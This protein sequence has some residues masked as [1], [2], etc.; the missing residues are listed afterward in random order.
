MSDVQ[1]TTRWNSENNT[2]VDSVVYISLEEMGCVLAD[3]VD[4][5]KLLINPNSCCSIYIFYSIN[6]RKPCNISM[7]IVT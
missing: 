1:C 6:V 4:R 3:C 7:V 2:K 5:A